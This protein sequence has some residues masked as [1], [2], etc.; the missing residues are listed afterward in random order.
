MRLQVVTGDYFGTRLDAPREP[1][2]YGRFG[3]YSLTWSADDHTRS[4]MLGRSTQ[5]D[6]R[7]IHW[8]KL[9]DEWSLAEAIGP[10]LVLQAPG[11]EQQVP[12]ARWNRIERAAKAAYSG[13]TDVLPAGERPCEDQ[14]LNPLRGR[15]GSCAVG[16]LPVTF[17]DGGATLRTPAVEATVQG[18]GTAPS[19]G[20][21]SAAQTA[22]GRYVVVAYRVRNSGTRP[23][24]YLKVGLRIGG[25]TVDEDPGAGVFL[26]RSG[27]FPLA[28]G[29]TMELRAAFDVEP[30][31][32]AR[33]RRE[34][35]LVLPAA[36]DE[37]LHSPALDIAQGWIR[38]A[39]A[40]GRLP[41]PPKPPPT[42]GAPPTQPKPTGPP[43]I[44]FE[45]GA[46]PQIGF[47]ARGAYYASSFFP[48]PSSYRPGGIPVG[49]RA[50]HCTV[51][52]PSA[53]DRAQ[54]LAFARRA[55]PKDKVVGIFTRNVLIANC[56]SM[57]RWG[58]LVWVHVTPKGKRI[59]TGT[60][61]KVRGGRWIE[62]KGKQNVGCGIPLDAAAVWQL[63]VS[64]CPKSSKRPQP[65]DAV[66]A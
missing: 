46:G 5:P 57:G 25:R 43:P 27:S 61:I 11:D 23:L 31:L 2:R 6:A 13:R 60:E 62:N 53:R 37:R 9:R 19:V 38:L 54:M 55:S 30:G 47:A 8:E 18:V 51:P 21:G 32:A 29:A 24:P 63:D 42:P 4:V 15:T 34:G 35:A 16:G 10:R 12:S 33:A 41:V 20:T 58:I 59:I 22:S 52:A 17:V 26:A 66:T 3:V 39:R 48:I 50:G 14:R 36:L 28:P 7:G 45:R 40:P 64:H 56:A 49:S 1:D 65:D 44:A